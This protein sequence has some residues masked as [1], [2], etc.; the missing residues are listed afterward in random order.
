[1]SGTVLAP[2]RRFSTYLTWL[3]P[4]SNPFTHL[5]P[6]SPTQEFTLLTHRVHLG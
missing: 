3:G 6:W 2:N 5:P 4:T 1:M